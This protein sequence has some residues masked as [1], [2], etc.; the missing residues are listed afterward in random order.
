MTCHQDCCQ[1][2]RSCIT[3]LKPRLL[4]ERSI[5]WHPPDPRRCR[6]MHVQPQK[7]PGKVHIGDGMCSVF[8][9]ISVPRAPGLS[10]SWRQEEL[11]S[12]VPGL[13]RGS[14]LGLVP[15]MVCGKLCSVNPATR[16]FLL[17]YLQQGC[18]MSRLHMSKARLN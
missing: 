12:P 7:L 3:Y 14:P 10:Y 17:L 18:D 9:K 4:P 1:G 16:T 6:E 13:A 15:G 5:H 8:R 2:A 11:Y